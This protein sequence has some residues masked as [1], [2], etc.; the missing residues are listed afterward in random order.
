VFAE[1]IPGFFVP[2]SS[3]R[4]PPWI[5]LPLADGAARYWPAAFSPAESARLFVGLRRRVAWQQEQVLIFGRWRQVPRL[6]AWYGDAGA[7]YTYSGKSHDPLPW[8][9]EVATLRTRVEQLTAHPFNGVLLNLYRDGRDG[10]GWHSDNE[11]ELGPEP[12]VASVSFGA[13]R[14]FRLK[15][16][17]RKDQKAEL[18]LEDGSV[19]LISGATQ[20]N[21]LHSVP[22]T[23]KNVAERI[24]LSFRQVIG[25][26]R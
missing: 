19:L 8:T 12:V 23:S 13:P 24:N 16:K 5:D 15:H 1:S 4:H 14:R 22:K 18:L 20:A 6:V 11:P 3:L 17:R 26:D 9:D 2:D 21:W 10:M 7:S 25:G